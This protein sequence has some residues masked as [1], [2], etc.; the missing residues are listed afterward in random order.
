MIYNLSTQL[1]R[2]RFA[3]RT[4]AL[5]QKGSVI[6]LTEKAFR[7]KSQNHYLH[8]LLGVIAMEVGERLDYVKEEYFKRMIN[9]DLFVRERLDRF[10]GVT[11]T[12]RSSK[13]LTIE[14]MSMAI[15]RFKR[16]G[17]DNGFHMPNPDDESMLR[18]I[19]IEMGRIR[20]LL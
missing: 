13:E 5:L 6:E 10:L 9:A 3:A 12:L 1:D 4:N 7:T 15:D 11:K 16:W 2:E 19:E 14:E 17:L 18:M 20:H 8:L